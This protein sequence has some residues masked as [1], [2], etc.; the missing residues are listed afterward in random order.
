[1]TARTRLTDEPAPFTVRP[2]MD[3]KSTGAKAKKITIRVLIGLVLLAALGSV[4]YTEVTLHYSYSQGERVGFVQKISKKG[5]IC[6]TNE[7]ELAMVNMPGQSAQIV[8]FTVPDDAV[9]GQI[10]AL[11]GHRVAITYE[12]FLRRASA[13]RPTSSR[14]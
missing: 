13:I 6:K 12:G 7:G 2:H 1:M 9:V 10:E 3:L 11:N 14:A 5:W 8:N 4:L